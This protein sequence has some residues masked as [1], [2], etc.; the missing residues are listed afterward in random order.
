[1]RTYVES[2]A[3]HRR[4]IVAP[5]MSTNPNPNK[6]YIGDIHITYILYIQDIHSHSG[7]HD[8]D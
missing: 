3:N 1:M 6:L 4:E 2:G 5:K 7:L 8:I